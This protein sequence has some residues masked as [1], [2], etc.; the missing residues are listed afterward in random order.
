MTMAI[1]YVVIGMG[2]AAL[3]LAISS[4]RN[5]RRYGFIMRGGRF[6]SPTAEPALIKGYIFGARAMALLGVFFIIFGGW[7]VLAPETLIPLL[8][9]LPS[10]PRVHQ[11]Y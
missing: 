10:D 1:G 2:V 3:C 7:V 11:R 9:R 6:V 8:A 5:A 4:I